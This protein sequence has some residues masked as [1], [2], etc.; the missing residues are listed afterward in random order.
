MFLMAFNFIT[1]YDTKT[2]NLIWY[3]LNVLMPILYSCG[4]G[5]LIFMIVKYSFAI[6]RDPKNKGNYIRDM[7]WCFIGCSLLFMSMGI[8]HLYIDR[9]QGLG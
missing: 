6:M 4:A 8:G 1:K 9:M 3:G 5:L 7:V 2:S